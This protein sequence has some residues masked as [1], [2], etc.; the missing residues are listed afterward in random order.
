MCELENEIIELGAIDAPIEHLSIDEWF[1]EVIITFEGKEDT[2]NV[3]CKF[4][5]EI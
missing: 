1:E 5:N 4:V 2:G 3:L